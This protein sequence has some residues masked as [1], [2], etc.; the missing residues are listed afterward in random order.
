MGCGG[1]MD[2]GVN[3]VRVVSVTFFKVVMAIFVK[4]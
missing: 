4:V 2:I 3:F 1:D